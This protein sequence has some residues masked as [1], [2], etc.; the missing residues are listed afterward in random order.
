ME[1]SVDGCILKPL[2]KGLCTKHYQKSRRKSGL[3][4][5]KKIC[6]FTDCGRP[7]NSKGYCS[8]HMHMI[9]QGKPLRPIVTKDHYIN[10]FINKICSIDG[11]DNKTRAKGYCSNH[12]NRIILKKTAT[13]SN[14]KP[15]RKYLIGIKAC[16]IDGC[17]SDAKSKG[18]CNK[19]YLKAR[20]EPVARK[21]VIMRLCS[22]EGCNKKHRGKGFCLSHYQELIGN[23]NRVKKPKIVKEKKI[24]DVD[25]CDRNAVTRGFC[26]KHYTRWRK[27]GSTEVNYHRRHKRTAYNINTTPVR[28]THSHEE[29][30][31]MND[32][33]D[34]MVGGD[35]PMER[36]D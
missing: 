20:Y 17:D 7:H 4:K 26:G 11:C 25:N 32:F 2:A 34:E 36:Y 19:H 31:L 6:S 10:S 28:F 24:C 29:V 5:S 12:Y 27:H 16:I 21:P 13:A 1:C 35:N 33:F 23:H 14:A 15:A 22:I 18:L 9:L 3:G 8:G 30:M